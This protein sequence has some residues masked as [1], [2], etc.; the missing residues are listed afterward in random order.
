MLVAAVLYARRF[1]TPLAADRHVLQL[2]PVGDRGPGEARRRCWPRSRP[3]RTRLR[4]LRSTHARGR[5]PVRRRGVRLRHRSDGAAAR[6]P[7]HP[8]GPVASRSSG[9]PARASRPSPSCSPGSTTCAAGPC[10]STASTCATIDPVD[11]RR[12]VVMVTQEAYL[13]SGSVGA[14]IALGKPDATPRRDRGGGARGRRA[15]PHRVDAG[16]LR[17][18]GGQARRA[19]VGRAAPARVVRAGVP[20]RPGAADPR[21]G[22]QL[23]RRAR[24][25]ARAG[26]AWQTLLADRT[27]GRHRAP[28]VD[29]HGLRTGCS[30]STAAAI[31]EDGTPDGLVAAG[32]RFAELHADWQR[33]IRSD[34]RSARP[35]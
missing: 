6:R 21:R 28:A 31:V 19:P 12:A 11:L 23:A 33:S 7:A 9:R 8:G 32:G 4:P 2:V 35:P 30:S 22:D 27:R 18:R 10:G 1:F 14:N 29:G 16:R 5:R 26:R 20:G 34:A 24:G 3:S 13:F 15:R 25:G 17:H